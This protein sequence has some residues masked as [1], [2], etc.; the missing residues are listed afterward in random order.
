[1][2]F[3]EN[4]QR[5]NL[6]FYERNIWV[7]VRTDN[8]IIIFQIQ[9]TGHRICVYANMFGFFIFPL[10][11][12][13]RVLCENKRCTIHVNE[14]TVFFWVRNIPFTHVFWLLAVL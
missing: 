9:H 5:A 8:E 13:R 12:A 3:A 7:F 11:K 2:V 6:K 1:M 14:R 4:E 10:Q